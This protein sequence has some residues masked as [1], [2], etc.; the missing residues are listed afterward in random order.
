MHLQPK[1]KRKQQTFCQ[2]WLTVPEFKKWII[3][4]IGKSG[5]VVPLYKP[6]QLEVTC[7]K[8][9]L[10]RHTSIVRHQEN[11]KSVDSSAII[12]T[13]FTSATDVTIELKV[14]AFI[15][16]NALPI[17][18]SENLVSLLKSLFPRDLNLKNVMLGK[19]KTTNIIRQVSGFQC[20]N[21][22]VKKLRN[23]MFSIINDEATDRS[24][25]K[26]LT[27][28]ATYFDFNDFKA[29]YFLLDV[30]ECSDSSARGIN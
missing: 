21:A 1:G 19:Q 14:C 9:G 4:R 26:Q 30:V 20:V 6:C 8:T 3:K 18:M 28:L 27:I 5:V 15:A 25:K 2:S 12:P 13:L 23:N 11:M 16:E 24:S 17:W 7:S 22:M 29:K 10:K